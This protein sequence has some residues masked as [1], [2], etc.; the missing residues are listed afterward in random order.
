MFG[1]HAWGDWQA[2]HPGPLPANEASFQLQPFPR[3]CSIAWQTGSDVESTEALGYRYR[4]FCFVL[5]SIKVWEVVEF[6]WPFPLRELADS[7]RVMLKSDHMQPEPIE[8]RAFVRRGCRG[9][10][11]PGGEAH[12]GGDHHR[13]RVGSPH[14][15]SA[16][17]ASFDPGRQPLTAPAVRPET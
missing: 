10:R 8:I 6:D 5:P 14:C 3:P 4:R 1:R 7:V 13:A 15:P 2:A 12:P 16:A 9:E 17:A 11:S